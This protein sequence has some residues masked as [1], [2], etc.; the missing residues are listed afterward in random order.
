MIIHVIVTA[1]INYFCQAESHETFGTIIRCGQC[2][3]GIIATRRRGWRDHCH[4]CGAM[5]DHAVEQTRDADGDLVHR[6]V[7]SQELLTRNSL[8]R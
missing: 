1:E 5:L 6:M 7:S 4:H 8:H 2:L 3:F